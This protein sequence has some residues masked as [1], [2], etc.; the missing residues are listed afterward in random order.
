MIRDLPLQSRR[1]WRDSILSIASVGPTEGLASGKQIQIFRIVYVTS[2]AES[3]RFSTDV[4][5]S[6]KLCLIISFTSGAALETLT[7]SSLPAI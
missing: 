3:N 1:L 7:V 6:L 4:R 5:Q 2:S